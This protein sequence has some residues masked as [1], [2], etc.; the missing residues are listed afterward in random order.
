LVKNKL[1]EI[2][3]FGRQA[4]RAEPVEACHELVE[5]HDRF[6]AV[7]PKFFRPPFDKALLGIAEG[8]RANGK[9]SPDPYREVIADHILISKFAIRNVPPVQN[10]AR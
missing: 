7:G 8:L 1:P 4:V 5:W 10:L 3:I 6:D 2:T 9:I